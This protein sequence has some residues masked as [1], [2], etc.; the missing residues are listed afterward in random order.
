MWRIWTRKYCGLSPSFSICLWLQEL[1]LFEKLSLSLGVCTC[2]TCKV[3]TGVAHCSVTGIPRSC[4][5]RI[6]VS[7]THSWTKGEK[8]QCVQLVAGLSKNSPLQNRS[9]VELWSQIPAQ[10]PWWESYLPQGTAGQAV[11]LSAN[12]V[13]VVVRGVVFTSYVS[14]KIKRKV[15]FLYLLSGAKWAELFIIWWQNSWREGL[16][17]DLK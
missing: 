11:G 7:A 6:C 8:H 16:S 15:S 14:P 12:W 10:S 2:P 17:E 3:W 13:G 5:S 1:A 4:S 9:F